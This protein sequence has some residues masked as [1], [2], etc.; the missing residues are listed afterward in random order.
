MSFIGHR[1]GH[2]EVIAQANIP[3]TGDWYLGRRQG[4]SQHQPH[5][6]FLRL[7]PKEADPDA[8][9]RLQLDFEALRA[10]HDERI[11]GSVSFFESERAMSMAAVKGLSLSHIVAGRKEGTFAMDPATLLDIMIELSGAL[12]HAHQ[13]QRHHGHLSADC[14][15]LGP[16]GEVW[17]F[18]FASPMTAPPDAW[19]PPERARGRA[20][21]SRTDQWSLAAITAALV[22]GR[23]PWNEAR[24]RS[25]AESG[26]IER[27][28][29][30][31]ETQWPALGRALRKMMSPRP[32]DR[33]A[34]FHAVREE[35][36]KL[37]RR[38]KGPSQ[39]R[40]LS[41]ELHRQQ[42]VEGPP[43]DV[44]GPP[45]LLTPAQ[46]EPDDETTVNEHVRPSFDNVSPGPVTAP[47]EP[48]PET[49]ITASD[50]LLEE[51]TPTA[52]ED[53][54]PV[55]SVATIRHTPV[56]RLFDDGGTLPQESLDVVPVEPPPGVDTLDSG[57]STQSSMG[58]TPGIPPVRSEPDVPSSSPEPFAPTQPE[59]SMPSEPIVHEPY[60][61]ASFSEPGVAEIVFVDTDPD[62]AP[63]VPSSINLGLDSHSMQEP[64]AGLGPNVGS[65]PTAPL[66]QPAVTT[67][68][69]SPGMPD[70]RKIALPMMAVLGGVLVLWSLIQLF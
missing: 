32:S 43:T 46:T 19:L 7:L 41:M 20:H 54:P 68:P 17:V 26:D 47:L 67:E 3:E 66:V 23:T 24:A 30:P 28:V 18:G 34:S 35:F 16:K 11:P 45:S 60:L 50:P 6:V 58:L 36:L 52:P 55:I 44:E 64:Q 15:W 51:S 9:A 2:Y 8:R 59:V 49:E 62:D 69:L 57:P 42:G 25:D 40:A 13:R 27:L 1:I 10:L 65:V 48:V 14:V 56:D 22:T 5:E 70:P 4:S 12:Q 63:L 31:V 53:R 37:A 21:S 39:R 29:R 61:D 38:A 33:F